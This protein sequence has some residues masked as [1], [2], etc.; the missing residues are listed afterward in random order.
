MPELRE[1]ETEDGV[2]PFGRWFYRLDPRAAAR[3]RRATLKLEAGLRPNVEPV[4]QGVF[5][6]K[7][8][9]GPGYRVY[10]GLDGATLVILLGGGDKREQQKD[11]REA[12]ERW[13][14][15]KARKSRG[16]SHGTHPQLS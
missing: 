4:G 7:I 1:Y 13:A 9:F 6:A 12:Q 14:N 15:Y 8:D 2:S 10:F 5:E 11:I 16:H 3:A